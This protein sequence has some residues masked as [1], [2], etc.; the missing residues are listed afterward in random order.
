[1]EPTRLDSTMLDAPVRLSSGQRLDL[2][3]QALA[4]FITTGLIA[5]PLLGPSLTAER[6]LAARPM[7]QLSMVVSAMDGPSFVPAPRLAPRSRAPRA[8][9]V[10]TT[11]PASEPAPQVVP[12]RE[13]RPFGRRVATLFTGS[14]AYAIRPFPTVPEER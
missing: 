6:P 12:P 4:A 7:P 11:P 14:G 2:L 3:A 5:A 8:L 9:P 1:M 10:M 13:R